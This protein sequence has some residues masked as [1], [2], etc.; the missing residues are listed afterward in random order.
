MTF[1]GHIKDGKVVVDDRIDL[2]NGTEVD[3]RPAEG[4]TSR[5]SK[6]KGATS[7][8]KSARKS[9]REK[10][11]TLLDRYAAIVGIGRDLPR[12]LAAQHDHYARGTRKR[13]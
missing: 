2:P 9:G 6:A 5:K 8:A 12:D 11:E 3:I 7:R 10:G 4:M 1:R 13:R